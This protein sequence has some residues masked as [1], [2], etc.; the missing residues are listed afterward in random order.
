MTGTVL[1][2]SN[3]QR[4]NFT[5]ANLTGANLKGANFKDATMTGMT[6]LN[7]ICPDGT[8]SNNDNNTCKGHGGG[9]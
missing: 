1:A 9:L 4:A 3:F 8:N 2:G 6:W 7:T 5:N